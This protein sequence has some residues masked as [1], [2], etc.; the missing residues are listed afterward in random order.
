MN[1]TEKSSHVSL[2]IQTS[3]H[4]KLV[5]GTQS[6]QKHLERP[7][8]FDQAESGLADGELNETNSR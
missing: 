5:G 6:L 4:E 3:T 8:G 1:G 7:A 2:I